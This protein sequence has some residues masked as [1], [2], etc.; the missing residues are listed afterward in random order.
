MESENGI[1]R[2]CLNYF[3]G[4]CKNCVEDRDPTHHPNNFDCPR[5]KEIALRVFSVSESKEDSKS[6]KLNNK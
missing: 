3:L 5:Y 4:F 2:M 6:D 1:I